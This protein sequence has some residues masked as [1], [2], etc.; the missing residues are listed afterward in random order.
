MN[1]RVFIPQEVMKKDFETGKITPRIN[2]DPANEYGE[3]VILSRLM[4]GPMVMDSEIL[5]KEIQRGLEGSFVG[6]EF[7]DN[8]YLIAVGTPTAIASAVASNLN[9]GRIRMLY[10]HNRNNC[11]VEMFLDTLAP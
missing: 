1:S 3:L 4:P 6:D 2:L 7:S 11:Y 5:V 10:W 9:G 8:D